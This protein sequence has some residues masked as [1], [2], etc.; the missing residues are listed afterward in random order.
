MTA[1]TTRK[2]IDGRVRLATLIFM[3][4]MTAGLLTGCGNSSIPP[5]AVQQVENVKAPRGITIGQEVVALRQGYWK[6]NGYGV[7]WTW[8]AT[9]V[10]DVSIVEA[11]T[12]PGGSLVAVAALWKVNT[13]SGLVTPEN[14]LARDLQD[15]LVLKAYSRLG[16]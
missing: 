10:G 7:G 11:D 14:G 4:M 3:S 13:R 12:H 2:P 8:N 15:G 1:L 5:L 16:L 9:S 6:I